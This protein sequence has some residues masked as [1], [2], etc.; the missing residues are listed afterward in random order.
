MIIEFHI[1]TINVSHSFLQESH[2]K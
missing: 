2:L 1:E